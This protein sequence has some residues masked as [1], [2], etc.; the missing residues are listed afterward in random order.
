MKADREL[1][2]D[3]MDELSWDPELIDIAPQIGVTTKN[4]MVTLS[5]EVDS[6]SKKIAAEKAAQRVHGVN[7]VAVDLDIKVFPQFYKTDIEIAEIINKAI[8]WNSVVQNEEIEV[9]VEN[10]WVTLSGAVS[11]H[12][13]RRA[14]ENAVKKITGI[15]GIINNIQLNP[16]EL[17]SRAIHDKI[18]AAFHRSAAID[19]SSV[20]VRIIKNNVILIGTVRSWAE[21]K[22]AEKAAW[23]SPGVTSVENRLK[24]EFA[25]QLV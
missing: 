10:G 5:G 9:L 22:E 15:K 4:G 24:V 7:V 1:Q 14:V 6:Y 19:S 3:V 25:P 20:H 8:R 21:K 13:E 23:S 11:W 17:E 18:A 12:F 2:K 16:V